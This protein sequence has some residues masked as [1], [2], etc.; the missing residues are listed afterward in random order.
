[1]TT[2]R[3]TS[4]KKIVKEPVKFRIKRNTNKLL[5]SQEHIIS[6]DVKAFRKI[7]HKMNVGDSIEINDEQRHKFHNFLRFR[8]LKGCFKSR[9]I[10][11]SANIIRFYCIKKVSK[12]QLL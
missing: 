1:M 10:S 5:S 11:K 12:T 8:K 3:K 2:A 4:T 7:A 9:V 6:D